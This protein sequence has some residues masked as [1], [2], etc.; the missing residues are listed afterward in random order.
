MADVVEKHTELFFQEGSSDKLYVATL[1]VHDDGSCSVQVAWGRRG[2]S[3]S[4]GN[5][6]VRVARVAA[7]STFDRLLREKTTKGYQAITAEVAPATVAPPEG[8]GSG[9]KA[10]GVKRPVVGP[11]AQLLNPID[12]DSVDTWLNDDDWVAQQKLDGIRIVCV[13][14][15][16][17]VLPLN[18]EGQESDQV[19]AAL[20]AGLDSLPTG[21][22]VDGEVIG[23]SY[24]LFDVLR[25]GDTDVTDRGAHD[26]WTLLD[27]ELSPG[28]SGDIQVLPL[29]TTTTQKRALYER[30]VQQGAEGI[31]FKQRGAPYRGGR[32][33]SGGSQR[34]HK[35]LK[36][37][38]VVI[39][40]NAGNAYTMVVVQPGP[41]GSVT[42]HPV[43]K[44]FA[45][46]TN[47]SRQ[48]LD[49][50]LADGEEP[51]CEV[52]YLYATDDDKLFQPVFIR[53]RTDKSGAACT[54]DQLRKTNKAVLS[55]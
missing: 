19:S 50:L 25:L 49:A 35:L 24:W 9:S 21:T 20:V 53:L 34:K 7:L 48:Q 31:V 27:E 11:K 18:R 8:E 13:V 26:R 45:G 29:A 44:V 52:E 46:T 10:G 43:G 28:L 55:S 38:D 51:V 15:H 41:G 54:R 14:Q 17:G 33:A 5:K 3:L 1:V 40:E 30:L 36:R 6:A 39:T 12:D 22:I 32:P 23:G 37:C 47:S 16:K 2:S 4:T 42:R